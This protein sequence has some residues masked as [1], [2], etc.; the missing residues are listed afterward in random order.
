METDCLE[1]FRKLL[2][3]G[4]SIPDAD[5]VRA[6]VEHLARDGSPEA[7]ALLAENLRSPNKK[8][9]QNLVLETVSRLANEGTAG[10]A[11]ELWL[12]ARHPRLTASL[13]EEAW[14]PD[15]GWHLKVFHALEQGRL[16]EIVRG[17]AEVVDPLVAALRDPS[18][19]TRE[20]AQCCLERLKNPDAVDALCSRWAT[21]RSELLERVIRQQG[22]VARRPPTVRVLSAL[23]CL[24]TDLISGAG[25][26][27]V[28]P[29]VS[30]IADRA[31]PLANRALACLSQL[32][33]QEAIDALADMWVIR[34]TPELGRAIEQAGYVASQPPWVRVLSA[35][36]S[37]RLGILQDD[38]LDQAYF[39]ALAAED[40]DPTIAGRARDL[41]DRILDSEQA[42]DGLC[43]AVIELGAPVAEHLAKTRGFK[44]L[45]IGQRA[46]FYFLTEQWA[47]Y[48]GLDFDMSHLREAY[49]S[50][51]KDL[52]G[53]IGKRARQAGRLELV[54]LVSGVRHK[55]QMGQMTARE[56][57]V[58]LGI[59]EDRQDWET[60]WRL[61]QTAPAVWS[62]RALRKLDEQDWSPIEADARTGFQQLVQLALRCESEAPILGIVDR[63]SARFR[64]HGRRVTSLLISSF[65]ESTLASSSWDSTIR[66]WRMPGG[67]PL[68]TLAGHTHPIT[69]LAGNPDGSLLASGCGA[70][71]AVVLWTMPNGKPDKRL[72]GHVQGVMSL[73]VS[74][75]GRLLAAGSNDAA[76]RLWRIRDA[77]L[78]ATLTGHTLPIRC[79]AFSPDGRLLATAG[80]DTTIRLWSLPE[81]E[82]LAVLHG[83]SRTVRCL[84]FTPDSTILASGAADDDVILWALP[85]ATLIKRLTGHRDTVYA[86]AV[87]GD[88]RVLASGSWDKTV[89]LWIMPQGKAWGMLQ[90]GA[91]PITCLATDPESRMLVSGSHDSTI[92]MWNFQSGIFRRPTTREEMDRVQGLSRKP[93]D[94]SERTWLDFLLAQ[95]RWR[96]RFDIEIDRT[97]ARIE[98]GQFDIEIDG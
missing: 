26:D 72:D 12:A 32:E 65:F 41:L 79:I 70:E 67:E 2:L 54:E 98:A 5:R 62:V 13:T 40:A 51:G 6:A 93:E 8:E 39:V 45:D 56:W 84:A 69:C 78:L 25:A 14:Q 10:P 49:A 92:T 88:G 11:Y 94:A 73:A 55:R 46:L 16:D 33:N 91:G 34:R 82:P 44:P 43:R 90:E 48:E 85:H 64:A 76:C 47:D 59:L 17:G 83:H 87:S 29:L 52:R 24:R 27:A 53:R 75:D 23:L 60:L 3:S 42:Q 36:Q 61:A 38:G 35:L 22:Y 96:W 18:R 37:G 68:T 80:E 95:M 74:A 28:E 57:G 58:T 20:Q 81:G 89:R 63:P 77:T 9:L 31:A 71:R 4:D 19:E 1:D 97:P 86:L 7:I 50:A 30:A 21:G 15:F 66:I